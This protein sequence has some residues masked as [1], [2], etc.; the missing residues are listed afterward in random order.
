LRPVE[1]K[2]YSPDPSHEDGAQKGGA[3]P[4][5]PHEGSGGEG[6]AQLGA[7]GAAQ[8]LEEGHGEDG[9]NR[10]MLSRQGEDMGASGSPEG[11]ALFRRQA[12]P[13]AED[14][15]LEEAGRA[16]PDPGEGPPAAFAQAASQAVDRIAAID[17]QD[18]LRPGEEGR[19]RQ[20]RPRQGRGKGA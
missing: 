10:E 6:P 19:P 4:G 7:K 9:E 11:F 2:G 18:I 15:G 13:H 20:E 12:V 14:Q 8:G 3:R 5:E 17:D 16:L 1:A